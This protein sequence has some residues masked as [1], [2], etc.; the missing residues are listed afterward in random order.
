M[1]NGENKWGRIRIILQV[2]SKRQFILA[3]TKRGE[4][5]AGVTNYLWT[6]VSQQKRYKVD[7]LSYLF[8]SVNN[9]MIRVILIGQCYFYRG[10]IFDGVNSI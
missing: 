4:K 8:S 6:L 10:G 2:K 1:L 9:M 5:S 7:N 3:K